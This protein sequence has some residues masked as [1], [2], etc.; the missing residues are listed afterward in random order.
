MSQAMLN[1]QV[2]EGLKNQFDLLCL[3]I[4]MTPTSVINMFAKA[5]VKNKKVLMEIINSESEITSDRALQTFYALR[6][7]AK[8]NG[9]QGFTLDE[10]NQEI[11]SARQE[12]KV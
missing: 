3:E 8:E 10:I 1:I 12:M 2:D 6:E 4:G 5:V 7:E 11:N 9:L